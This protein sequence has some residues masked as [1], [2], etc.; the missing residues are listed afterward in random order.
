MA[1]FS[2]FPKCPL[3]AL[4]FEDANVMSSIPVSIAKLSNLEILEMTKGHITGS[5]PTEIG[6]L[7]NL[8]ELLIGGNDSLEGSIPNEI[9]NLTM[10]SKWKICA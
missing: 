1:F 10:L 2:H 5:I 8:K 4:K 6:Y 9:G 7:T 3:G